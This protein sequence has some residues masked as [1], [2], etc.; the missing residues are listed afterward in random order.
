[1][2]AKMAKPGKMATMTQGAQG[3]WVGLKM[4]TKMATGQ[5]GHHDPGC[6]RR[7][8]GTQDGGQDGHQPLQAMGFKMAT[9][10]P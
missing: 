10:L 3:G 5:N 6:P 8:G 2:V 4:V 7:L 1:M 9:G